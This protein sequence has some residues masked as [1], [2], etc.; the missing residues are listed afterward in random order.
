MVK[1][2]RYISIS[3]TALII[4]CIGEFMTIFVFAAYYPGYSQ[5]KEPMSALGSP[6]SPVSDEISLWWI[7][8]GLLF[9]FFGWGFKRAFS[10]K[11]KIALYAS[12]LIILYGFGEGIGSGLFKFD[13]NANG[14]ILSSFIHNVLG[15]IGT[16]S[17]LIFPYSMQKVITKN[18]NKSFYR[19][20]Q[21]AFF[22]GLLLILLFII[23][24][25][26]DY[27]NFLVLYKGL[28]QRLFMLNIYVYMI[29]LAIIM[30]RRNK[31]TQHQ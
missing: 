14:F 11:G 9:I 31:K 30:V 19:F 24:Y 22:T 17:I 10:D 6:S 13:E 29:V 7:I 21:I 20:S 26:K 5:L 3:V 16:T 12:L 27:S 2:S 8:M 4:A 25:S 23:R 1:S 28:W 18:E 15:G